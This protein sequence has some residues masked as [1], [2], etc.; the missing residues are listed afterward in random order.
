MTPD[1]NSSLEVWMHQLEAEIKRMKRLKKLL[2]DESGDVQET[3]W[4]LYEDGWTL[5]IEDLPTV[6][7]FL[8]G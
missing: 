1:P 2:K 5:D 6:A 3:A 4:L 8:V 7:R